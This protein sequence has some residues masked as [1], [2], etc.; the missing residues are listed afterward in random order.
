MLRVLFLV[1]FFFLSNA[2]AS[3]SEL[4]VGL[5]LPLT[6]PGALWGRFLES[7]ARLAI[8]E[9]PGVSIVVEDDHLDA[10]SA[11]SAYRMLRANQGIDAVLLFGSQS[12][13]AVVPI[14]EQDKVISLVITTDP[15]AVLDTSYAIRL[16]L[17]S[18]PQARSLISYIKNNGEKKVALIG[19]T[20]EAM[21]EYL[22]A[23]ET[24]ANES[25]IEVA[26]KDDFAK[27]E[28]DFRTIIEKIALKNADSAVISLLP[29]SL[30]S[31]AKQVKVRL[32]NIKL[33]GFAQAENIEEI[34]A[35]GGSLENLVISS[36]KLSKTFIE[37]Y[38][39]AYNELPQSY[40]G[41]SY[42]LIS[43]L[44]S[45]RDES[46]T[47]AL[48]EKLRHTNNYNGA[49]GVYSSSRRNSFDLTSTIYKVENTKFTEYQE[50][51]R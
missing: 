23:F 25:N 21:L 18:E 51:A 40:A 10:A 27:G 16:A 12:A 6:G 22:R 11:V 33:Y 14:A 50:N 31:F 17:D 15:K 8:D 41:Y 46:N 35:A 45:H 30:S 3:P 43:L 32:P 37:K 20:Q 13:Q 34:K 29:P 42:D 28:T 47:T 2:S 26:F 24:Q 19:T 5:I 44:A 48:V 36:L 7:G 4:K 39:K 9:Q 38:Q 1:F 49:V